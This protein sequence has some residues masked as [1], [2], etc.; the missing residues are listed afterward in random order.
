[1]KIKTKITINSFVLFSTLVILMVLFMWFYADSL[2]KNNIYTYL[3]SSNR[4]KAEHIRTFIQEEI[5]LSKILA[6]ASVYRDFLNEPVGS[7]GYAALKEKMTQRLA[8]TIESEPSIYE[9]F[10]LDNKGRVVVSSDKTQEGLDKSDDD[11]FLNAKNGT[12]LKDIYF[13]TTI[14]KLT[15]TISS[16]VIDN[17][18]KFLGVSV[19]RYLPNKFFSIIKNE[20]EL[21]STEENFLIDKKRFFIS[22]SLFLGEDVILKQ[23]VETKNSSDC[24]DQ[25][26]VNYVTKNG[27]GGLKNFTK[28]N[29]IIEALDYRGVKVIATHGY[30]PETGW[31]LITKADK[32]DLFG[33]EQKMALIFLGMIVIAGILYL[34]FGFLVSR[35]I[36]RPL[37]ELQKG[38]DKIKAG[39]LD[40][41][42]KAGSSDEVSIISDSFNEM[43]SSIKKSQS[44][45]D[46]KVQEQTKDILD[47]AN[48]LEDQRIAIMNILDD[49]EKGK[50]KAEGLAN[51]LEKFKLAVDNASDQVVITDKE[52]IVV[53]GNAT[54]ERITGY[55]PQEALGK[56]A[57]ILWKVPMSTEYYQNLWDVI[58]NKKKPFINEIQNKRKNGELYFALISISPVLNNKGEIVYFVAIERDITKE[59]E[60]DKAKTEFVSLASHQLRTPLSAINWYT[61][62]LLAGDAGVINEEQK[63]YLTEVSIGNQRMVSLVNALLNV[64]RLDL[65]TFII[66]PEAT[67]VLELSRSVLAELK[68]QIIEKKIV[69]KENYD[70]EIKDFKA[71]QKLLRIILQN[72]MSNAVKYINPEGSLTVQIIKSFKDNIFGGK[73]LSEDSLVISISDSGIGIPSNQKDKIFT[74]LFRADNARES[75]TEGTGLGL[76]IVK[77]I[78]DQSGGSVWFDSEEN[79]GTTFYV[80]IPVT[81][82]KKK[83]GSKKLD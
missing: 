2:I 25:R 20:N 32:V 15:Y 5:G 38:I 49:V 31:C 27:Y 4:A 29:Q 43:T 69:V 79:K 52:G 58:K 19:L 16:P 56:K 14:K 7:K 72:L 71:D 40:Y 75:E 67:D 77:S 42:I 78:I 57:G 59:K 80:T 41:E 64:S 17:N 63:K 82:M 6:A 34:I 55:T 21:G 50:E 37:D 60:V 83:E 10:V 24:F 26:E 62:M 61:E 11:Y 8:R 13:S 22:P 48:E 39:N 44:E 1:M 45:I 70:K 47:K 51:D 46:A 65:G 33:F 73:K 3:G 68:P 30:I 12:Y 28:D 23:K 35:R 66:E 53:Y 18:G 81:G 9:S 36:I 54:V 74:K 76:Y